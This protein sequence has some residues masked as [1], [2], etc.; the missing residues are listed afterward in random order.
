MGC[1]R[2]FL[3]FAATTII[4]LSFICIYCLFKINPCSLT[5]LQLA[6]FVEPSFYYFADILFETH[7]SC[8]SSR[9]GRCLF[10][11]FLFFFQPR[12]IIPIVSI[13]RGENLDIFLIKIY[14][15]R[16][17]RIDSPIPS[18]S[19]R[20]H[21][22]SPPSCEAIRCTISTQTGFFFIYLPAYHFFQRKYIRARN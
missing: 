6:S 22:K 2:E 11:F 19:R 21:F 8:I 4:Y 13:N 16:V 17:A 10:F 15:A 20:F 14:R 9:T 1:A 3:R 5:H 12:T 7:I 18:I